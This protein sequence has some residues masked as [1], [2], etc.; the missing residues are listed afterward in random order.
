M[1]GWTLLNHCHIFLD[2]RM[3]IHLP[4]IGCSQKVQDGLGSWPINHYQWRLCSQMASSKPQC[5][6]CACSDHCYPH[7]SQGFSPCFTKVFP[8]FSLRIQKFYQILS[9][10]Y[11][12][13]LIFSIINHPLIRLHPVFGPPQI[14]P[15]PGRHC[16]PKTHVKDFRRWTSTGRTGT[17]WPEGIPCAWPWMMRGLTSKG[18]MDDDGGH[19]HTYI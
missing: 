19:T 4:P 2:A 13:S 12:F 7:V 8:W 11:I 3:K 14:H 1:N 18:I 16:R 15:K 9:F 5:A 17:G 10:Q 6:G